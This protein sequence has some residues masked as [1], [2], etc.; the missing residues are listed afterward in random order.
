MNYL[1][2]RWVTT[3]LINLPII[4]YEVNY[5]RK[6]TELWVCQWNLGDFSV[7]RA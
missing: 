6:G 3:I 7:E 4:V 2:Y 1:K 5:R